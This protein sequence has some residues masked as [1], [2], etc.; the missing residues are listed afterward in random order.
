MTECHDCRYNDQLLEALP[1]RERVFNN[2]LWR[3][4]H[5]FS[6]ALPGWMVVIPRRHVLSLSELTASEATS[7]GPLLTALS[8]ALERGLGA[9]KAYLA[10]FAE[11]KGFAHLH[12]H[13]VPRSDD[14]L[15]EQGPHILHYLEQPRTSGS[16]QPRWTDRGPASPFARRAGSQPVSAQCRRPVSS[17]CVGRCS[18]GHGPGGQAAVL[19]LRPPTGGSR[20]GRSVYSCRPTVDNRSPTGP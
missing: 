19:T 6:S 3:V 13:V 14:L 16:A 17:A 20:A 12:L 8:T 11:A 1:T 9:R 18:K 10:F 5:A 15:S 2:G 4:A 7:L